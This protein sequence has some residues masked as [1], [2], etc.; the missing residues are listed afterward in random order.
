MTSSESPDKNESGSVRGSCSDV[1]PSAVPALSAVV[2][3]WRLPADRISLLRYAQ[4]S[5]HGPRFSLG[6]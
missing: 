4:R 5:L 2:M 3:C 1:F 6:R